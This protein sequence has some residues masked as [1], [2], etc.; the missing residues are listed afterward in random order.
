MLILLNLNLNYLSNSNQS[1][2]NQVDSTNSILHK[3][4]PITFNQLNQ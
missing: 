1:D 4:T 2:M 3:F